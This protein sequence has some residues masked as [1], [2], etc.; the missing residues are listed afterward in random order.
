M[1]LQKGQRVSWFYDH[2]LNSRSV[3]RRRKMGVY[4]GR[5]RHTVKHWNKLGSEQMA[6]VHFD[7][8]KRWSKIPLSEVVL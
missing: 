5:C 4:W 1:G 7:G 6:W 8:N 3:V 2:H